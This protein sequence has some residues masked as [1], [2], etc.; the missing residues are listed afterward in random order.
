MNLGVVLCVLLLL[1]SISSTAEITDHHQHLFSPDAAAHASIGPNGI[2]AKDLIA[3]LDSAGIRRAVVLSVAY[4]FANPNK[5][6][7]ED[8]YA[9]V[10]AE[11]DWTSA[12]VAQYP[13]RLLGFCSVN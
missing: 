7:F 11:N 12:Q 2:T 3:H 6:A 10:K 5:K 9:R 4:T 13:R 8:E 1:T